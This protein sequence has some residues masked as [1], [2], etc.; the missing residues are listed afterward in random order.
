MIYLASASPRRQDLLRQAGIQF[1]VFPSNLVEAQQPN[2]TPEAYVCRVAADKARFVARQLSDRGLPMHPVLG[3]DTEVV[4]DKEILGKPRD[5]THGLDLLHRLA[6]R[7]H[8]VLTGLCVIDDGVEHVRISKSRV[9]FGPLTEEEIAYYWDSGEPRDKAG[10]YA[11]QGR[12]AGFIA[13]IEGSY[14]GI[15][16]LPLYEFRQ[17]LIEIGSKDS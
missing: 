15:V 13:R 1:E 8:E 11:I 4:L 9:T 16:G 14:S 3:A 6:G 17:L 7:Q 2:E 5:R 10:G 12:G